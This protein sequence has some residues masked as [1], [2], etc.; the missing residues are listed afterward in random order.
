MINLALGGSAVYK[1]DGPYA[2]NVS[3]E[4]NWQP[5]ETA[6]KDGTRVL[7]GWPGGVPRIAAHVNG[8]WRE[9]A[10]HSKVNDDVSWMP[11]PEAPN[12]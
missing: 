5:M 1:Q 4:W 6:P 8:E 7:I 3:V 10:T 12:K 11:L 2:C 9:T